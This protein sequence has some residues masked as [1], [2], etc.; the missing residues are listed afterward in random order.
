[1][2]LLKCFFSIDYADGSLLS[3][4]NILDKNGV[5]RYLNLF[6]K[7][8]KYCFCKAMSCFVDFSSDMPYE[9]KFETIQ[10][11]SDILNQLS[12]STSTKSFLMQNIHNF[13]DVALQ[14]N[15]LESGADLCVGLKPIQII[16]H[17]EL[18]PLHPPSY[19][20]HQQVHPNCLYPPLEHQYKYKTFHK[21]YRLKRNTKCL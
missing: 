21:Q 5:I 19:F 8:R 2:S 13:Q 1:M 9:S 14:N 18:S 16:S 6:Y 17:L 7:L 15:L 10:I 11:E 20:E 12:I 3:K 4:Y